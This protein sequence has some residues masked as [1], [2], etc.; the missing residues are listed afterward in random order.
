MA[1]YSLRLSSNPDYEFLKNV[2]HVTLKDHISKIWGWDESTQDEFFKEEFESGQI[3]VIQSLG[4]DI[5]YL[6]LHE[7]PDSLYVVELLILPQFQSRGLGTQILIDLR[8]KAKSLGIVMKMGVFKVN[9][10]AKDLYLALGFKV[11][12]ETETHFILES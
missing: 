12:G 4:N 10:R 6:I 5:G 3:H 9:T 11:C 1:D 8:Q 2:H 7:N